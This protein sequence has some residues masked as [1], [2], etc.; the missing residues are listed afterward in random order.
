[1]LKRLKV[2]EAEDEANADIDEELWDLKGESSDVGVLSEESGHSD[3]YSKRHTKQHT[4]Y[5]ETLVD[6]ELMT[7]LLIYGHI[8]ITGACVAITSWGEIAKV[9]TRDEA[10]NLPSSSPQ[11]LNVVRAPLEGFVHHEHHT[12]HREGLK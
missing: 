12:A 9:V 6:G 10:A 4:H 2:A 11:Q 3:C 7:Q 5:S 8:T 1:M